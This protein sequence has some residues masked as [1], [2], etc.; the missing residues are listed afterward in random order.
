MVP[1][2][3]RDRDQTRRSSATV[4]VRPEHRYPTTPPNRGAELF[5]LAGAVGLQDFAA[6][7]V[8]DSSCER[9]AGFLHGEEVVN[10][11]W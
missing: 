6:V 7:A 10:F 8:K 9:M 5:F 1:S 11:A 3:V 2:R 4:R